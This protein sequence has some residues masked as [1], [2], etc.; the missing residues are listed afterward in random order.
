[1]ASNFWNF[2]FYRPALRGFPLY[3][4]LDAEKLLSEPS[5]IIEK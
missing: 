2:P 1:M 5:T 3:H 4:L